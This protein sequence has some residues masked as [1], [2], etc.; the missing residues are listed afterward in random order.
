MKKRITWKRWIVALAALA[1][2][3]VLF[4]VTMN[5]FFFVAGLALF[6]IILI[7]AFIG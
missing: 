1:V 2:F 3:S 4:L 5:L 6:F 7:A